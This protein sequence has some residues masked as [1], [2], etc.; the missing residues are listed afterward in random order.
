ML[1]FLLAFV[2]FVALFGFWVSPFCET[3]HH[4]WHFR[5]FQFS[6]LLD[7]RSFYCRFPV[8]SDV[9]LPHHSMKSSPPQLQLQQR[10]AAA[11]PTLVLAML[12]ASHCFPH[13]CSSTGFVPTH[14][15]RISLHQEKNCQVISIS[16]SRD[17]LSAT[18]ATQSRWLFSSP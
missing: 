4:S 2:K 7:L 5:N 13:H 10:D 3:V 12:P 9:S 18:A 14:S 15:F 6:T 17:E 8:S 11:A 16:T 1:G